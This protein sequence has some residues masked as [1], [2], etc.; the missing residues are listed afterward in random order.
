MNHK[1]L[2]VVIS[3]FSGVGKGTLVK[4]LM[5]E[6]E[7]YA[8]SI[9]M[10]TRNPREG[11][12]H[13]REYFFVTKE[14]FEHKIREDGLIEFASYCDNYYGT[15]KDYVVSR[16]EEGK[17]VILE[18]EIQGAM[19]IKE[20]FPEAVLLFVMAPTVEE[21]KRR[22]TGRGTET[23]EAIVKRLTRAFEESV[24]IEDYDYVILNDDLEECRKE[25]HDLIERS[26]EGIQESHRPE[27]YKELIENCRKEL[28]ALVKGEK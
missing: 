14:E 5:T 12:E 11:E 19:K 1:G 25:L 24:G 17:N 26:R 16:L 22:L 23:E 3:G 13:G 10:T 6:Y 28:Q 8:L 27:C 2:L 9:S 18:I 21:L 20:R 15:P 7:N 4:R